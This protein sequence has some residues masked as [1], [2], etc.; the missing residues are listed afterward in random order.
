MFSEVAP[1]KRQNDNSE[2]AKNF[3]LKKLVMKFRISRNMPAS[4]VKSIK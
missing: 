3:K 1:L 2:C 4:L